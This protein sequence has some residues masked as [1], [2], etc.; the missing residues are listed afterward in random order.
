MNIL[1]A[2]DNLVI[3][4]LDTKLMENWGYSYDPDEG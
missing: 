2:E 4:M 3:Q 1:I